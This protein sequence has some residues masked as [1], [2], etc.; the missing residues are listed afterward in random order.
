MTVAGLLRDL[1]L[2]VDLTMVILTMGLMLCR[3]LPVIFMSSFLGG[4]AVPNDVRMG[5]GVVLTVILF[6]AVAGQIQHIPTAAVP[7]I[8]L[9]VKE[10]FVGFTLSFVGV[11]FEI[12]QSAGGLADLFAGTSM[13]QVYVPSIQERTT[14]FSSIKIQLA[15]AFFLTLNGHHVI[16][17]ALGD[18]FLTVPL[19]AFPLASKGAWPIFDTA[20]RSFADVLTL[21]LAISA[22]VMLATFLTDLSLGMVNKVAP[23]IQV[24]FISMSIKPMVAVLMV[25]AVAHLLLGRMQDLFIDMLVG[26]KDAI[27]MFS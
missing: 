9:L 7:F 4:E 17:Q 16:I 3:I 10:L 2:R 26:F 24:Y 23:Q 14:L 27:R 6:P 15:I 11:G 21:G 1:G 20:I 5:L 19:D 12:F 18:S 25:F 13:A 8:L 22:P